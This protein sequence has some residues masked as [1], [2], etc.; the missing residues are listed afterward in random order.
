MKK[1]ACILLAI[2]LPIS[3]YCNTL[4]DIIDESVRFDNWGE[5]LTRLEEYVVENPADARGHLWHGLVLEQLGKYDEA[6]LAMRNAINYEQTSEKKGE[7]YYN[8][9]KV[10]YSKKVN[11]TALE[12]FNKATIYNSLIP[13]PW[14]FIGTIHYQAGRYDE[15]MAAWR[16][17]ITLSTDK[18]KNAKM[19][20]VMALLTKKIE[21][22]RLRAEEEK[23]LREEFLNNLMKELEEKS[24]EASSLEEYDVKKESSDDDLEEID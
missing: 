12:M 4:N 10:Y 15:F 6:I 17:F 23:R 20:R 24:S 19:Q 3:L 1:T 22:D 7:Y 18:R 2:I 16:K 13:Q 14:Y 21:D 8:L 5:A 11:E 9:G